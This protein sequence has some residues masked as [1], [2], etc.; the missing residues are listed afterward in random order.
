MSKYPVILA[1]AGIGGRDNITLALFKALGRADVI[2]YDRLMDP[3]ILDF[4]PNAEKIY[5]G[6]AAEKHTMAQEDIQTL[7][8]NYYRAGKR[9]IRLKGG[10]P[11][12]FGRGGEE[13]LYLSE[14]S[15]PFRVISGITSG[16]AVP[17]MAGI[18][19][20]QRDV[21]TSVSF[22]TGHRA[23]GENDFS[24]Y[25][26]VPGTLVFYMGLRNAQKIAVDLLS[27]GKEPSTPFAVLKAS[28]DG[29][30]T[31]FYSSLEKV[32][33]CGLPEHITSP[34]LIVVGDVVDLHEDLQPMNHLP[35]T[36]RKIILTG[37]DQHAMAE[38]LRDVGAR[39]FLRPMI[40]TEA[41]NHSLLEK[42][43]ADFSYD[44]LVFTSKNAVD[45]FFDAFL[46]NRDI[47]DLAGTSIYVVGEKTARA[48]ARYG[49]RADGHPDTYD[50]RHLAEFLKNRVNASNRIYYPHAAG[51]DPYLGDTLREIACTTD[52]IIY[53]SVAPTD[54]HP[55]PEA[56]DAVVFLSPSAVKHFIAAYGLSSIPPSCFA[57]GETT[58]GS[59]VKSSIKEENIVTGE[60][61]TQESLCEAVIE[62]LSRREADLE[63]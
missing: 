2:V 27:G 51:S 49:L 33:A 17:A 32:A 52:R 50:G 44:A 54:I 20:T 25:A 41:V 4:A 30:V 15:I 21:A 56:Y 39:V 10:D 42:D 18:P 6:K 58:K 7:L 53:R 61:A 12:V 13:A 29:E 46:K 19:V 8:E 35:L 57:I 38:D 62:K 9:V 1:G 3:T 43:L 24:T 40:E 36:G 31:S 28:D 5:V 37:E 45:F 47:R 59:L 60:K 48:L 23:T 63:K 11:Y 34:G 55:L 14:R 22:I 26:A 16:V